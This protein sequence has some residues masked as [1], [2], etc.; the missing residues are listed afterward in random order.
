MDARGIDRGELI[1]RCICPVCGERFSEFSD[2]YEHLLD[3][4]DDGILIAE[5]FLGPCLRYLIE[6]EVESREVEG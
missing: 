2:L 5:D 3:H 6:E 4:I 1:A